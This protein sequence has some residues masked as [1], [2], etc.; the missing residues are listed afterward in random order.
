MKIWIDGK[1]ANQLNRVGSGQYA[2]EVIRNL[3]KIDSENEYT[4]LLPNKPLD[5]LPKPRK[6]W[7]YKILKPGRLWTRVTLPAVLYLTRNRPDVFFSPT[8]YIPRFS[9]A[10]VVCS[11]FDLSFLHFSEMFTKKDLWQLKNWTKFSIENADKIL[12]ISEF[13]KKDIVKNYGISNGIITVTHLGYD[14]EIFKPVHDKSKIEGILSKYKVEEPYIIYIGT[15]QPKK[16][17]VRLMEAFS[18]IDYTGGEPMQLVIV[19]KTTEKGRK[20]WMYDDILKSPKLLGI[21]D[22]VVF[23]GFVPTEDLPALLSSA[24][25]FV[26]PS[27]W[28]GF[29]IPVLEAMACGA[30]VVISNISSLP[31]VA[32][33]A[34]ILIDPYSVESISESLMSLLK[35]EKLRQKKVQLGLKR[36]K[37]F[38]WEDCARKTLKVF[39]SI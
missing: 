22:R 23:T 36:I 14:D 25:V 1:E 8:H 6:N 31:E 26:L 21:E 13:T 18:R 4:I 11:I 20:G 29:G 34:G 37:D 9:P 3:E 12:A 15:I 32:G 38:S 7:K 28:E 16:N 17:L 30:P 5:D 33:E 2:F 35:D 24:K 39:K 10:P 27:L 19:G